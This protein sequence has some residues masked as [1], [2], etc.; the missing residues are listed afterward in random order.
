MRVITKI[1][2]TYDT[3]PQIFYILTKYT[4]PKV[5]VLY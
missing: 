5:P 4:I 1:Q 3:M 2:S